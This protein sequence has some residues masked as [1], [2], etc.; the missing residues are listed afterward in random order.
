MS[1]QK[2]RVSTESYSGGEQHPDIHVI[3]FAT[4]DKVSSSELERKRSLSKRML[5]LAWNPK[6]RHLRRGLLIQMLQEDPSAIEKRRMSL[7]WWGYH[8]YLSRYVGEWRGRDCDGGCSCGNLYLRISH[9][10]HKRSSCFRSLSFDGILQHHKNS[11][12]SSR[13]GFL[14]LQLFYAS[15]RYACMLHERSKPLGEHERTGSE[16]RIQV[17][18]GGF[19]RGSQ[20]GRWALGGVQKTRVA[21]WGFIKPDWSFTKP[22]G[23]AGRRLMDGLSTVKFR[24]RWFLIGSTMQ[25]HLPIHNH[26]TFLF[27]NTDSSSEKPYA[28]DL[29]SD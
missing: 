8:I 9:R 2:P 25:R 19:K 3:D 14:P 15:H 6:A 21:L 28:M 1:D 24:E 26:C 23:L 29:I 11:S 27:I 18:R 16:G 12:W 10:L 13:D 4:S 5:K 17:V 7:T 20:G 22:F